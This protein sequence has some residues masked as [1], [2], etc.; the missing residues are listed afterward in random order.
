MDALLIVKCYCYRFTFSAKYV[1]VAIVNL[2]FNACSYISLFLLAIILAFVMT[3]LLLTFAAVD[4]PCY[5][6]LCNMLL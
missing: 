6:Q 5:H 4:L 2:N 1:V 3:D